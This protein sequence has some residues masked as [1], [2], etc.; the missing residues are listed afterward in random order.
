MCKI[1]LGFDCMMHPG[2]RLFAAL[3]AVMILLLGLTAC[4]AGNRELNA[5]LKK[6][7]CAT[8]W[9]SGSVYWSKNHESG[10]VRWLYTFNEDGTGTRLDQHQ[11]KGDTK[12]ED[13]G[14]YEITYKFIHTDGNVYLRISTV[15]SQNDY[16]LDYDAESGSILS[17][18]GL[19]QFR[20]DYTATYR[21]NGSTA[22]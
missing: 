19:I 3:L 21:S 18:T 22:E 5:A 1:L 2:K 12:W 13:Q 10:Y 6:E 11:Y 14:P 7:L 9:T 16:L 20:N 17:F 4:G 15:A 8:D